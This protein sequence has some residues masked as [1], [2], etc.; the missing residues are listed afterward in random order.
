[1][2]Q[3]ELCA[4]AAPAALH[5]RRYGN[6]PEVLIL[7]PGLAA[8]H[9]CWRLMIPRLATEYTVVAVDNR[10][11]GRTSDDGRPFSIE[12]MADDIAALAGTLGAQRFLLAG[13]SMG[14]AIAQAVAHRYPQRV[15]ALALCN[16]F[17]CFDAE[18]SR[19]ADQI[20]E[21]YRS[22]ASRG[23]IVAAML[24][25]VFSTSFLTPQLMTLV[26]SSHGNG[27]PRQSERDYRRQIAALRSFDSSPWIGSVCVPTAII[28]STEDLVTRRKG[29]D[30]LAQL[31]KGATRMTVPGG[32]S[33]PLE[34][35]TILAQLLL[36]FFRAR[37]EGCRAVCGLR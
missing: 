4:G 1:M 6:A 17:V 7:I 2:M 14:G 19:F 22:G 23:E 34:Q 36:S 15:Q 11:A 13:H 20:I 28:D 8:D 21:L 31:I 27:A 12:D 9:S 30:R 10:G 33:S 32:H 18:A 37:S 16:T 5:Y 26:K 24:P 29:A 25:R 35:P 3:S